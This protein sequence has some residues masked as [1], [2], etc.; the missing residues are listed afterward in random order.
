MVTSRA[1]DEVVDFI[2]SSPPAEEILAFS[3]S[4]RAQR[5]L[6]ELLEKKR[7]EQLTEEDKQEL[8]QAMWIEHL[9]RMAK[10]RARQRLAA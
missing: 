6:E 5:R 3:P 8:D 7:E 9:M 10:A 2:T 1:F 4:E